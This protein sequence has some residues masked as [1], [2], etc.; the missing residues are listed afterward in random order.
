MYR[1]SVRART[2]VHRGKV[3]SERMNV[4]RTRRKANFDAPSPRITAMRVPRRPSPALVDYIFGLGTGSRLDTSDNCVVI[5]DT[6]ERSFNNGHFV[7]L[8]MS[9][10][11]LPF[12]TWR[13]RITN[14]SA[15]LMDIGRESL[16]GID[17]KS[18]V[19]KNEN[20]PAARFLYY[21]F[22]MALLQTRPNRQPG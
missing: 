10:A 22:I 19:Y 20:R 7:L 15:K 14:I 9:L 21:H 16:V 17:S 12:K 8:P 6:V 1:R 11:E 18:L 13:F 2:K 3:L 5:H 4:R